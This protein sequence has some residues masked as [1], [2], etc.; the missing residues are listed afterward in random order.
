MI[1]A[2]PTHPHHKN[3]PCTERD[4]CKTFFMELT[5]RMIIL[6]GCVITTMPDIFRENSREEN[7]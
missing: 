3:K 4:T 7:H 6:E 5:Y 2:R 1:C